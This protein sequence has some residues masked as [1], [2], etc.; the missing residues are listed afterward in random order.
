MLCAE[1][2]SA[3]GVGIIRYGC[4]NQETHGP[5]RYASEMS[6]CIARIENCV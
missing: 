2:E 6:T 1:D 4:S 5:E 3:T